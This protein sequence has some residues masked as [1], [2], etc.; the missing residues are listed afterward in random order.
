M[1]E[2]NLQLLELKRFWVCCSRIKAQTFHREFR[3][4]KISHLII[5]NHRQLQIHNIS[6]H[7]YPVFTNTRQLT[8]LWYMWS[9]NHIISTYTYQIKR[10]RYLCHLKS[11]RSLHIGLTKTSCCFSFEKSKYR[12]VYLHRNPEMS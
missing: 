10:L 2:T 5:F 1:G 11:S 8:L 4:I 9:S 6:I 7:T 3:N 12:R